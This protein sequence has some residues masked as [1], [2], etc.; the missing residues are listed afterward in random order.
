MQKIE[1]KN[2]GPIEQAE[3]EIKH[4]VVLIG[5]QASG[6]STIGKLIYFFK[7]LK[8]DLFAHVYQYIQSDT[9]FRKTFIRT[10]QTKFYLFFGAV[11]HLPPFKIRYY[12]SYSTGRYIELIKKNEK[13]SSIKI[14]FDENFYGVIGKEL[15]DILTILKEENEGKDFYEIKANEAT[16]AKHIN[17]L[18]SI[19]NKLFEDE[20]TA[21]FVPAGRNITVSYPNQFKFLFF[22]DISVQLE[23]KSSEVKINKYSDEH[24]IDLHLMK[25]FLKEIEGVQDKF[26]KHRDFEGLV[27]YKEMLNERMNKESIET[28]LN[29]INAILKGKYVNDSYSEKIFFDTDKNRYV[30]LQ[31]ASSGQQESI[32]ILQDLFLILVDNKKAFRVFEEPEAHLYP[33]A[34]KLIIELMALIVQTTESTMIITTHSPYILS[35]LN[36]LLYSKM[37]RKKFPKSKSEIDAII[38]SEIQLDSDNITAYSLKESNEQNGQYSNSILNNET[39][40][41]DQNYLDD[42]S[43]ELSDDFN[44]LYNIHSALIDG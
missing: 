28:A 17:R 36:N 9:D 20:S 29:I 38:S 33:K 7:A 24:S 19:V 23:K 37:L 13:D 25:E 10:I 8:E 31:N 44:E 3:I 1:I 35:V 43:E 5:E 42:I 18:V 6:K 15:R 16:K 21:L 22:G 11:K 12:Y 41:I 34:Q 4:F 26:R 14:N 39:G 2:F 27:E 40:L 30:H 32:R